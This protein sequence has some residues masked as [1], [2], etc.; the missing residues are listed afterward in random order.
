[1]HVNGY[2]P[3]AARKLT[4]PSQSDEK[5]FHTSTYPYNVT[6]SRGKATDLMVLGGDLLEAAIDGFGIREDLDAIGEED[7]V[8]DYNEKTLPKSKGFKMLSRI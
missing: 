8:P 5:F 7:L 4:C 6:W 1:M 2:R 3:H